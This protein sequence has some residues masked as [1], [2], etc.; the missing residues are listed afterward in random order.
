MAIEYRWTEGRSDRLPAMAVDLVRRQVSVIAVPGSGAA[1]IAAKAATQTI[2]IVFGVPEDPVKLGLVGSLARP[3]GNAT[4][5]NFFSGR[6]ERKAAWALAGTGIRSRP[7]RS[8]GQSN[9]AHRVQLERSGYGGARD[10][11]PTKFLLILNVKTAKELGLDV[12][13][14]L[15]Q[16]AD[17]VIE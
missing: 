7:G 14:H 5:I 2:P 17:E 15:Q 16:L 12:P 4:G 3:G 1:A 9:R 10:R 13:A 8:V 6:G 11:E